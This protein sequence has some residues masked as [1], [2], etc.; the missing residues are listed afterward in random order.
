VKGGS[1]GRVGTADDPSGFHLS[2]L[3]LSSSKF[4]RVK[5]PSFSI[6]G[7]TS[8]LNRVLHS[9]GGQLRRQILRQHLRETGE[10]LVNIRIRE[11]EG[12]NRRRRK[13]AASSQRDSRTL[14]EN[15]TCGGVYSEM[16][17]RQK[18]Q[19]QDWAIHTSQ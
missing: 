16:I 6:Q 14:M 18:I 17:S 4:T 2:K 1:P 10:K 12:G 8:S 7:P 5:A 3:L 13:L 11:Q 15:F 19:A 9:V